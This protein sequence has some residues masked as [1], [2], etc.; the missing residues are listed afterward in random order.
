MPSRKSPPTSAD[1]PNSA[2][3]AA[4]KANVAKSV[5]S[6]W[7]IDGILPLA[8]L[9]MLDGDKGSGKSHLAAAIAAFVTAGVPLAGR[10]NGKKASVIWGAGE[11]SVNV[12]TK[13]K[14]EA[15][16][17][18]LERVYFLGMDSRG[19]ESTCPTFP[20]D[21]PGLETLV[22]ETEATFIFL[23]P[24]SSYL[25]V[26]LS[27]GDEK[28]NRAV[29]VEMQRVSQRTGSTLLGCRHLAK[30]AAR[31]P[32][33]AGVGSVAWAAVARSVLRVEENP[34]DGWERV[35]SVVRVN[36]AKKSPPRAFSIV[37]PEQ[38]AFIEWGP[39][40]DADKIKE[41][42]SAL[43]EGQKL[44]SVVAE[45]VIRSELAK[46]PRHA[47]E[48]YAAGEKE[49]ISKQAMWRAARK[50]GVSWTRHGYGTEGYVEWKL[51]DITPPPCLSPKVKSMGR[52]RQK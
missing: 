23:D 13:A 32:V 30:Q 18:D 47:Q 8:C 11:E 17:A 41:L 21:L 12:D 26:G 9:A 3:L 52:K 14:L 20:A 4:C 35:L 2:P 50:I 34:V 40:L 5:K 36:R 45:T 10:T 25:P 51:P 43:D 7:L 38:A 15:A 31:D 46:G 49:R 28:A 19:R 33:H 1:A 44:E 29:A 6:K 22:R 42:T 37:G 39:D 24:L 27:P 16:G 48:I